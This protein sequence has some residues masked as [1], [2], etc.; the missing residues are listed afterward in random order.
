MSI[1]IKIKVDQDKMSG[2]MMILRQINALEYTHGD[3]TTLLTQQECV[4]Y[5][6]KIWQNQHSKSI[7]LPPVVTIALYNNFELIMPHLG[8][9]EQSVYRFIMTEMDNIFTNYLKQK[10]FLL[11]N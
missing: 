7:T 1:K 4:H 6:F 11:L 5:A 9:F 3:I 2:I 8:P 10:S